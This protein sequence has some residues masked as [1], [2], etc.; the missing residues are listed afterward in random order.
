MRSGQSR[1]SDV[2]VWH[3]LSVHWAWLAGVAMVR[4]L[5]V[6][7]IQ[8]VRRLAVELRPSALDDFGLA[9]AVERLAETFKER[10]GL[11][12][13]LESRLRDDRLPTEVETA[14]YRIVQEGL[15]NIVKHAGAGHVSIVLTQTDRSVS[16]VV[17]DDGGGFDPDATSDDSLGL[18]GMR[19]RVGL[20]GGRLRVE[21]GS[22]SGTTIAAE[23]PLP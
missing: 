23:V 6:S 22:G 13:D 2:R 9:T 17:E 5:V 1:S 12:V 19:E 4:E 7:T 21:S 11:R 15:A 16:A 8:N 18:V 14:L 20:V 3:G 10:T